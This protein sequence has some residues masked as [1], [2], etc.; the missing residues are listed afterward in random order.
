MN[1]IRVV[2]KPKPSQSA[3][4]SVVASPAVAAPAPPIPTPQ[5]KPNK[6]RK[7]P[8]KQL[9]TA[10]IAAYFILLTIPIIPPFVARY[11]TYQNKVALPQKQ[12]QPPTQE[13]TTLANLAPPTPVDGPNRLR[14]GSISLEGEIH[15][16]ESEKTLSKGIWRRPH[17]STP[18]KGSN[19]VLAAHRFR[20]TTGNNTFFNLDKVAVGE[21]IEIVWDGFLYSYTVTESKVV[22]SKQIDI[23]AP[24]TQDTLTLYTCTPLWSSEKRLVVV[25]TRN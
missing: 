21:R 16:G 6:S 22:E 15:D 12:E 3:P 4:P 1:D 24:T 10:S 19:T 5:P 7:F 25:A 17:T 18:D 9:L 2:A 11:A 8:G 14:V 20:Y 23:E 13:A